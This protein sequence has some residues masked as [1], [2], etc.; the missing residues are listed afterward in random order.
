MATTGDLKNNLERLRLEL[1]ALRYDGPFDVTALAAG[2][3]AAYLP[4][5]HHAFLG[6]SAPLAEWLGGRGYELLSKSDLR[7]VEL[8]FRIS[9]VEFGY[10]HSLTPAQVLT[11]GFAERK[12][13]FA[14]DMLRLCA[15]KSDQLAREAGAPTVAAAGSAARARAAAASKSNGV[16]AVK[17]IMT[18]PS[19]A[20]SVGEPTLL[21]SP[22]PAAAGAVAASGAAG[23]ATAAGAQAS[24]ARM[25]GESSRGGERVESIRAPAPIVEHLPAALMETMAEQLRA[26]EGRIGRALGELGARMT[27]LETRMRAVER[28]SLQYAPRRVSD[29]SEE[30]PRMVGARPAAPPRTA[31]AAAGDDN[32]MPSPLPAAFRSTDR[33]R[34]PRDAAQPRAASYPAHLDPGRAPSAAPSAGWLPAHIEH[35]LDALAHRSREDDNAGELSERRLLAHAD[36]PP[37][38]LYDPDGK[39]SASDYLAH[40]ERRF[41]ATEAL[42]QGT[43]GSAASRRPGVVASAPPASAL[44]GAQ[45]WY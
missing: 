21:P 34:A 1:R 25:H 30:S 26:M 13:L 2:E 39:A 20:R 23:D 33:S 19:S 9:R 17:G 15:A 41:E 3:P 24:R 36:T 45:S 12:A 4:I 29:A 40:L 10:R 44:A 6:A 43:L 31:I 16:V 11:A 7:F 28:G 38:R 22:Q 18:T 27:L 32:E 14:V 8:L 5:L 35:Q 42:V 37:V